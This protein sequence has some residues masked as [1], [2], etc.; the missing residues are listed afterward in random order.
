LKARPPGGQSTCRAIASRRQPGVSAGLGLE[1]TGSSLTDR[2]IDVKYT[3]AMINSASSTTWSS[4]AAQGGFAD[5]NYSYQLVSG[6]SYNVYL[7][8]LN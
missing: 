2:N 3:N 7:A 8:P 4:F 6:T 1:T 5:P